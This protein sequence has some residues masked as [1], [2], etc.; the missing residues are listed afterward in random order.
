MR[1][2]PTPAQVL[3]LARNAMA[4]R[5]L[6]EELAPQDPEMALLHLQAAEHLEQVIVQCADDQ[7]V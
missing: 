2:I 6:V 3:E 5:A 1:N 7:G 4:H